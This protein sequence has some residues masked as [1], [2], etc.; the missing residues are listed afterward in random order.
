[1]V[2]IPNY[3]SLLMVPLAQERLLKSEETPYIL[4]M[5]QFETEK[6]M[7]PRLMERRELLSKKE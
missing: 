5:R 3:S 7:F 4:S 2:V 1:M 6:P